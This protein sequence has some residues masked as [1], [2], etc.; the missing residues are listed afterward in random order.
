MRADC[1]FRTWN[2]DKAK[3]MSPANVRIVSVEVEP[4]EGAEAIIRKAWTAG[5]S[6]GNGQTGV[7]EIQTDKGIWSVAEGGPLLSQSGNL[8]RGAQFKSWDALES[9]EL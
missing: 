6:K 2:R 8:R 9:E 3:T 1:F 5:A 4:G 7:F